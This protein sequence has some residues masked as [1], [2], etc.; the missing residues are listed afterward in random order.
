MRVQHSPNIIK[1]SFEV[2]DTKTMV[3]LWN[4]RTYW[5][6]FKDCKSPSEHEARHAFSKQALFGVNFDP[7]LDIPLWPV[8]CLE[9]RFSISMHTT[10]HMMNLPN[11]ETIGK[12]WPKFI[13]ADSGGTRCPTCFCVLEAF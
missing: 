11:K 10:I 3:L 8:S 13:S 2:Q 7:V 5:I 4:E 6:D 12:M 9:D 1:I